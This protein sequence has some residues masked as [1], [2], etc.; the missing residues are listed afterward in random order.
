MLGSS[1]FIQPERHGIINEV[2]KYPETHCDIVAAFCSYNPFV[3]GSMVIRRDLIEEQGGYNETYRYVQDYELWSRI[4]GKT[5]SH[6]LSE[7]LY[8]RSVHQ[9][10]SETLVDKEPIFKEI[11]DTYI[12]NCAEEVL[13]EGDEKVPIIKSKSLYPWITLKEGWNK[14][15]AKTY[16]RMSLEARKQNLPWGRLF[17]QSF[18]HSPFFM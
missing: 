5:K 9:Q 14:S 15:I 12:A 4:L 10:A 11:R 16:F 17:V 1:C 3:H 8:V 6:N 18:F 13:F 2:Y 7:P